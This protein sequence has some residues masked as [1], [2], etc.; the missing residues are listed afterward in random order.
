[1]KRLFDIVL[2]LIVLAV[3]LPF[4]LLIAMVIVCDTKGHVFY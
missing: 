2:S 4:G 1:M 3:F